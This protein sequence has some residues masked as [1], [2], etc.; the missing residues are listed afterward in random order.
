MRERGRAEAVGDRRREERREGRGGRGRGE[1]GEGRGGK[2]GGQTSPRYSTAT[3]SY[4]HNHYL[5]KNFI[6]KVFTF[7]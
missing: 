2:G 5:S 4:T 7:A 1:R 6:Q 3:H